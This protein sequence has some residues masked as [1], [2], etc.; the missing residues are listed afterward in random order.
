[1]SE[2]AALPISLNSTIRLH[3]LSKQGENGVVIVGRGDQFLELPREGLDFL[4]WLDEGLTLAKARER[5]EAHYNPF[6]DEEVLEVINAFVECDFVAAVNGQSIAPR[7]V[8]LQSN[9]SWFPQSWARALFSRP[10][11]IA[12]MIIT[13]PAAVLWVLTPEL[14]PQRAD[15]FWADH[16]SLVVLVGMLVWLVGMPLHELA[17]WLACRAKGIE[18]TITWT[19]RLGFFPMSQTVMHNIWAVPR[20]ARFLPLAAGMVWDVFCLS[21]VLYVL[22]FEKTGL[23][24][25]PWVVVRLLKFYILI[26]TMALVAQFWLFSKMDGYFLVSALLGQRNLQSEAYDWLKSKLV[27]NRTFDAP[28]GG[29]K[30]VHSYVVIMVLWGGLFMGQ[31]LLIN[32]PIKVQLVWESFLKVSNSAAVTPPDFADGAAVLASQAI[33]YGLLLYAYCRDTLPRWR[34][35]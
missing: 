21:I 16:Y 35:S 29:M 6:P 18:A 26:I 31:F 22:Y 19:Q 34:Q 13:V 8:P 5:F 23:L 4:T 12:W 20:T 28:A 3:P 30:F 1:M 9:A 25:V 24:A 27:K 17:H 2:A 32:L 11:L 14:W 10:V 33:Y 7:R 15:Y